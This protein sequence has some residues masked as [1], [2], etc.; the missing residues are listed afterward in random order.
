MIAFGPWLNRKSR[1]PTEMYGTIVDADSYFLNTGF[2]EWAELSTQE[3]T[4]ALINGSNL[5]DA[6]YVHRFPGQKTGGFNQ[7]NQWPRTNAMTVRGEEIPPNV[8]PLPVINA[9]YEI[10]KMDLLDPGSVLPSSFAQQQIQREKVDVI[11]V[12]YFK[13]QSTNVLD[14]IPFLPIIE[15][16]LY[17]LLVDRQGSFPIFWVR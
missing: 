7:A 4:S 12:A 13:N 6:M 5:L 1:K 17:D 2:S 9:A 14:N 16:I 15:G 11:E 10:A 3:K 8:V